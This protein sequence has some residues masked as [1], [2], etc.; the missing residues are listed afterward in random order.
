[1][2]HDHAVEVPSWLADKLSNFFLKIPFVRIQ[3][4]SLILKTVWYLQLVSCKFCF[5]VPLDLLRFI[6][7]CWL[8]HDCG[9]SNNSMPLAFALILQISDRRREAKRILSP[10]R[11]DGRADGVI[12]PMQTCFRCALILFC[13]T[14]GTIGCAISFS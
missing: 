10:V 14:F 8:N 5:L 11:V 13:S 2:K 12:F 7:F 4:Q 9:R 1:M 3:L 6:F